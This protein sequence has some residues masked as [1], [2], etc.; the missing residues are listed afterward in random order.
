M[1][2]DDYLLKSTEGTVHATANSMYVDMDVSTE[3]ERNARTD[4]LH[5]RYSV[6][7]SRNDCGRGRAMLLRSIYNSGCFV[8]RVYNNHVIAY[9]LKD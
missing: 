2:E 9:K 1:A 7:G 3:R 6:N 4:V 5:I 8:S